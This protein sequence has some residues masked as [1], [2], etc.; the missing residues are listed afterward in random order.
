MKRLSLLTLLISLAIVPCKGDELRKDKMYLLV[1]PN[2]YA[3]D[4]GNSTQDESTFTLRKPDK[5][6]LAQ[7]FYPR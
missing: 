5:K 2:G 4:N 7:R 1:S 6:N 3:I